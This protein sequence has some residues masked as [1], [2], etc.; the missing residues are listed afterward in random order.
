MH[1]FSAVAEIRRITYLLSDDYEN[2]KRHARS[3]LESLTFCQ[4]LPTV[5]HCEYHVEAVETDSQ[6]R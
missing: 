1:A 2:V 6:L 4:L 3:I 5:Y